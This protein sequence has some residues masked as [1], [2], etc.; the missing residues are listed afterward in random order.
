VPQQEGNPM[1][2]APGVELA[3]GIAFANVESF[4]TC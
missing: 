2:I 1:T 4:V 3:R